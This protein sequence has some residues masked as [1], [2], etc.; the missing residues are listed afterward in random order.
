MS[1]GYEPKVWKEEARQH[2]QEFQPTR[3]NEL[4]ASSQLEDALDYAVEQ[5]WAEM[6]SLM[7]GGFQA[8]EAWEM[9]RENYLFVHEEEGLYDDE[10]L[11]VNVM[12]EYNQWLHKQ[13]MR[14]NEEWLERFEQ[15]SEVESSE[16]RHYRKNMRPS[17]AWMTVFRWIIILP[18]ALASAYLASRLAIIVTGFGL[19]FEGYSN[20]SF[21][22]RF[23]SVTLE[24]VA[25]GVAFVFTAVGIAPSHKHI[26]AIS[27][28]VFTLLFTGFLIYPVLLLS[29]YWALWGGFCLVTAVMVSTSNLYRRHR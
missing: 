14:Q 2:W 15:E 11:P 23:Y 12:H 16:A 13:S 5:T 26:V 18:A 19:A 1:Y 28:S 24:H 27:T 21:F 10:E 29:D 9:V 6:Q 22:T 25:L 4:T 7:S 3:F 8:H 17:I 20:L